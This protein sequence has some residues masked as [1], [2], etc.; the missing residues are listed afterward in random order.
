M[1]SIGNR[2]VKNRCQACWAEPEH[3]E[4][5][6]VEPLLSA[7]AIVT[8]PMLLGNPFLLRYLVPARAV[9]GPSYQIARA[10]VIQPAFFTWCPHSTGTV[11]PA[12][13][14]NRIS[15]QRTTFRSSFIVRSTG[16]SSRTCPDSW[17]LVPGLGLDFE[18]HWGQL[19][20]A[21]LLRQR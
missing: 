5:H 14:T 16:I 9:L 18:L 12:M 2:L 20:A 15:G 11:N 17:P 10:W 7:P 6:N 1:L 13:P 8:L 3:P 21:A 4:H 19:F